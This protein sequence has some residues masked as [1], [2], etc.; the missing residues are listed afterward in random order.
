MRKDYTMSYD[1][2]ISIYTKR[3]LY[4]DYIK[5]TE[6]LSQYLT[7]ALLN[8]KDNILIPYKVVQEIDALLEKVYTR[9]ML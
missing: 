6:I 2:D 4:D 5:A 8:G 3:H 7:D 9:R 1:T